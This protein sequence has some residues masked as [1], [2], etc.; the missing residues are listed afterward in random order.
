MT[1]TKTTPKDFFLHLTATIVLYSSAIAIT[2]LVFSVINYRFPDTLAGYFYAGSIAWPI[3]TL[4]VLVPVLYVIEWFLKKDITKMPEKDGLWIRRWRVYLTLFLTG[5]TIIGDL[6]VLINTYINGEI[7][8]RFIYKFLAIIIIFGIIFVYYILEKINTKKAL[9]KVLAWIGIV[10]V[11]LSIASG[12][13]IVGSPAK[14]RALRF[15]TQRISDL[16]NIQYQVVNYW[17]QKRKLPL[18]LTD[19]RDSISGMTVPNDPEN[20]TEYKYSVKGDKSFEL[21][22]TFAIKA[23]VMNGGDINE[24]WKH[25]AGSTCFA[26]TVDPERYPPYPIPAIVKPI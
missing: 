19:L 13:L 9:Q 10:I 5:A 1:P 21:C 17:Q 6:I 12:F 24:N 18:S 20:K 23:E 14:Q 7:T 2:N 8:E 22:A 26:R 11:I 25:D 15:D 4:M 3:S 16:Q